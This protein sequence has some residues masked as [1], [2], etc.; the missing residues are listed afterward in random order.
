[1][2]SL[3][4]SCFASH[5]YVCHMS[6]C[7]CN[8]RI[9]GHRFCSEC[10]SYFRSLH[11]SG[12]HEEEEEEEDEDDVLDMAYEGDYDVYFDEDEEDDDFRRYEF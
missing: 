6:N 4:M 1:M 7:I 9:I 5:L 3:V 11:E 10:G 12:P 2:S 8:V